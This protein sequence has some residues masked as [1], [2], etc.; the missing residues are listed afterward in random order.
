MAKAIA[1][2]VVWF[3][4]FSFGTLLLVVFCFACLPAVDMA[5]WDNNKQNFSSERQQQEQKKD[6]NSL[7][8]TILIS[9]I[10]IE[11]RLIKEQTSPGQE[12]FST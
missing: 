3:V 5:Q 11:K 10:S 2:K 8:K 12:R 9:Q 6:D 4:Y 1:A 7:A